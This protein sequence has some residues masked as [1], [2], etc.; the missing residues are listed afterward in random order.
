LAEAEEARSD[1]STGAQRDSVYKLVA[2]AF[3]INPERGKD[4]GANLGVNPERCY[5][6]YQTMF[7]EE[8]KREDG[9]FDCDAKR[10]AL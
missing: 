3:D 2:G 10:H 8:A 4:F 9:S 5:P 1:I 7:E 6:N